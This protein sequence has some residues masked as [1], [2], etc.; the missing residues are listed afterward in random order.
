MPTQGAFC[1][2]CVFFSLLLIIFS[3]IVIYMR[4]NKIYSME[5]QCTMLMRLEPKNYIRG[6]KRCKW[7]MAVSLG[8]TALMLAT[9]IP[10]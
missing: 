1:V 5:V 2:E 4:D 7:I 8:F 10:G 9:L 6:W 3:V